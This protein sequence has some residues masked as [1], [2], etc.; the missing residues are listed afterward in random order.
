MARRDSRA[1]AG[2]PQ[3]TSTSRSHRC[4]IRSKA[5]DWSAKRAAGHRSSS[6]SPIA[7]MAS[8]RGSAMSPMTCSQMRGGAAGK[9]GCPS[10]PPP[11]K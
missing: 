10:S 1:Q 7:M 4:P 3:P 11:D 6:P 9:E 2:R 5:L 8:Q